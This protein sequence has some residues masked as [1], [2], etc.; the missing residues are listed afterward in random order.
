MSVVAHRSEAGDEGAAAAARQRA[1][2]AGLPS[3]ALLALLVLLPAFTSRYVLTEVL[4]LTFV[5]GIIALSLQFLAGYGGMVNIAQITVAGVGGYMVAVLGPNAMGFGLGWPWWV[6]IPAALLL[7]VAAS[8]LIGLLA[9]RTDGIYTIMITLAICAA[10]HYFTLQ[11][12]GIFNGYNGINGVTPPRVLGLDW[13]EPVAFYYLLLTFA[14]LA[15]GAALYFARSTFGLALQGIRDSARRMEAIGFNV[16]AHRVAAY[17][18]TGLI[19]AVGGI[20]LLWHN[21]RIS[22][23]TIGVGAAIDILI[24]AVI[25]GI[26]HPIGPFIGAL[27]F[28]CLSTFAMDIVEVVIPRERFK[29]VVGLG[30][31]LVVL[32]SPDG[33]MG[34]VDKIRE[35]ARRNESA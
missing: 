27:I 1:F 21:G 4:G 12:Y 33:V 6:A 26:R 23:G 10:F 28:V 24:M 15:Y 19:A 2:P 16:P 11:N 32:F 17:M 9:I 34:I 20:L 8:A 29:L 7:A 31:L 22:P 18:L 5:F 14:A 25:G 13:K 30:F 3:Y 35:S